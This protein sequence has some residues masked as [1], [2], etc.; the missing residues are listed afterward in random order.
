MQNLDMDEEFVCFKFQIR[1][2]LIPIK[3]R[4]KI[5]LKIFLSFSFFHLT[6]FI[7]KKL[8][9]FLMI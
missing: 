7:K 6:G 3:S 2:N 4:V 5:M 9:D 8:K 1:L